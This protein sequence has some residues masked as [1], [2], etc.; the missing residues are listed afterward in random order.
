VPLTS[1]V[2]GDQNNPVTDR[3]AGSGRMSYG[4]DV[5]DRM[6]SIYKARARLAACLS[7]ASAHSWR[8]DMACN[9]ARS[10][11]LGLRYLR[12]PNFQSPIPKSPP[13]IPQPNAR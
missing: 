3:Y 1:G 13:N 8:A 2:G 6:H 9:G 7:V 10:K 12:A 4:I 11:G 5:Q